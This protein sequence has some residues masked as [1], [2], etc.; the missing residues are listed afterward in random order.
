M[1]YD[2]EEK[3]I[4]FVKKKGNIITFKE[5]FFP[6]GTLN[7]SRTQI[8]V[9]GT[10]KEKSGAIKLEGRFYDSNWYNSMQDLLDAVDWDWMEAV[11]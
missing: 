9:M 11:H 5:P 7:E 4:K 6:K 10:R 2:T 1:R 8:I 3:K